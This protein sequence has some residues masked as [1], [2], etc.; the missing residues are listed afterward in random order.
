MSVNNVD[1]PEMFSS[2]LLLEFLQEEFSF[3]I[4]ENSSAAPFFQVRVQ[5]LMILDVL[6]DFKGAFLAFSHMIIMRCRAKLQITDISPIGSLL[7][8][9]LF[10][11]KSQTNLHHYSGNTHCLIVLF[12]E[13]SV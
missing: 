2:L 1:D 11:P 9:S 12:F 4:T 13:M 8:L 5:N 3:S 7:F 10:H 6:C